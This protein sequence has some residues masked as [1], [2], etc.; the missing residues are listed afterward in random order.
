MPAPSLSELFAK[1]R[2]LEENERTFTEELASTFALY[3]QLKRQKAAAKEALI[4]AAEIHFE[5]HKTKD[6]QEEPFG[7]IVLS[8][9][10]DFFVEN[11]QTLII[12]IIDYCNNNQK[13][14][15]DYIRL[16]LGKTQDLIEEFENVE[17]SPFRA[18]VLEDGDKV[19]N[20]YRF[21]SKKRISIRRR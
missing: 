11:L 8:P 13:N 4:Q 7:R 6:W 14:I 5:S 18:T 16:N 3:E 2:E 12:N 1:Y 15:N 20:G 19:G 21:V 17:N 10:R 9:E